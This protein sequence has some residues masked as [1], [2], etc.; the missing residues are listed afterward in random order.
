MLCH[1]EHAG[2]LSC[3]PVPADLGG[4]AARDAWAGLGGKLHE[5]L[6]ALVLA[7]MSAC[8][9]PFAPLLPHF[10]GLF[11]GSA[12]VALDAATLRAMR[13]KR[14]VLLVRFIAKA[15][16][17]PYYRSEWLEVN[18]NRL[19]TAAAA[20]EKRAGRKPLPWTAR[21][22]RPL[23]EPEHPSP[24]RVRGCASALA[25]HDGRLCANP[26]AAVPAVPQAPAP[27]ARTLP[28]P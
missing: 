23:Q 16:L 12:L 5:R 9:L 19:L 27:R 13:A 18:T 15:L 2:P 17:C 4:G 7:H 20:G 26:V 1:C 28:V 14:R 21:D 25:A 8:P 6:A 10:L 24:Q 11:V 3:P 22:T